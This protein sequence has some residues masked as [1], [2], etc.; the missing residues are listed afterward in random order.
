MPFSRPTL[1]ELIDRNQS[2]IN[3]RLPGSDARLRRSILSVMSYINARAG[4][5]LGAYMDFIAKQV[6]I[7]T[8]EAEF[9]KRWAAIWG[10]EEKA[11]NKASGSLP[12]TGTNGSLIEAQTLMQRSDGVQ[13]VVTA[14]AT[15]TSGT[16]TLALEAVEP[17]SN[18]NTESGSTLTFISTPPGVNSS[19]A[20]TS[21]LTGGTDIETEA[22]LLARLLERIKSP[23][24][25][26]NSEDYIQWALAVPGVTRAWVYPKE[27]GAGTVTVRFMMDN[28]YPDGIPE[29]EDVELVQAYI[30]AVRPVTA[31]VYIA[32][33]IAGE[34]DFEI[35][36]NLQDTPAI[37]DAVEAELRDMI[38]RD[39][40]PGGTIYLS[41]INEAISVANG[42]F[43]HTLI[44]PVANVTHATGHIAVFGDIT[45][46]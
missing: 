24:H 21:N 25:G 43:D 31:E 32:A 45:W 44:S 42:E 16:A 11:A 10:V 26:G 46:S 40:E 5:D 18:G 23:P 7:D 15:I 41:R 8:A 3:S 13:F 6:I 35:H 1:T 20:L 19:A 39:A 33:P 12:V 9:L 2:D 37:R 14:D 38:R 17:G 28:T 4:N 34:L 22:S 30:E 36:L 27:M 29:S